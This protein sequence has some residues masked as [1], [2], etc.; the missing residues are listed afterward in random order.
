MRFASWSVWIVFYASVVF[1]GALWMLWL[2]G[3][4]SSNFIQGLLFFTYLWLAFAAARRLALKIR[5][6]RAAAQL[7][8]LRARAARGNRAAFDRVLDTVPAVPPEPGDE[9]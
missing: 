8:Y 4:V 2:K 9:W 6:F 5:A 7:H 1:T 3:N